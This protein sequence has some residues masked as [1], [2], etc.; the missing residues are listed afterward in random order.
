MEGILIPMLGALVGGILGLICL[1]KPPLRRYFLSALV[2][3]FA[4]SLAFLLGAFWLADMNP[5][6]EYGR[7]YISTGKEHDPTRLDYVLWL[8][9][10]IATIALSAAV[11]YLIQRVMRSILGLGASAERSKNVD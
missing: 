2:T 4:A 9:A 1:V 11:S 5:A 7:A 8:S 3:P 10:V 6:R